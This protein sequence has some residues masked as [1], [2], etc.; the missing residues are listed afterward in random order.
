M[1]DEISYINK[2]LKNPKRPF[3]AILGG[4]KVSDKLELVENL[5]AKVDKLIIGGG[6]AFTFIKAT[7]IHVG[8]SLVEEDLID[9]ALAIMNSA[10]KK[11]IKLYLPVD[12][13]CAKEPKPGV[14]FVV[15][16]IYEIPKDLM[17]LDIGP[18]TSALF[19]EAMSDCETLVWNGPMGVFE[20]DGLEAGTIAVSD[21]F[22]S[23]AKALTIAGGGD[24]DAALK[25]SGNIDRVAFVST[26]GGAFLEMLGGRTL[27]AIEILGK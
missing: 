25:K 18:A 9:T 17:G 7:G 3:A 21:A 6:M 1:Q 2:A 20:I 27:P 23:S 4:A 16:T 24:T 19:A 26:A 8:K 5:L 22:T 11:G 14:N 15:K 13:V 12:C 10:K